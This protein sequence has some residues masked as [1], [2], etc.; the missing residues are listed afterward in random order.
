MPGEG[1]GTASDALVGEL[2]EQITKLDRELL[3]A[4]NRRI[5]IV[6][7]LHDYKQAHGIPLRDPS[8]ESSLLAEL[9][10]HNQGPLSAQ[11]VVE[12][13]GHLLELV[14]RELHGV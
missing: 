11:G 3:D 9:R 10:E 5:E 4:I 12:F 8:R 2:R 7:R 13:F 6:G 1:A 14:R